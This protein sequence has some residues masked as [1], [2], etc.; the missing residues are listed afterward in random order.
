MIN[1]KKKLI[2][3]PLCSNKNFKVIIEPRLNNLNPQELYGAASGIKGSQRLVKCTQCSLIYENPRFDEKYIL[4]GYQM[5]NESDHDSQYS[6]RVK[7][8]LDTLIKN[9]NCLPKRGAKILD[10]GTAGGAFLEAAEKFG[11]NASGLEPNNYLVQKGKLK[12]LR[13]FKGTIKENNL[14]DLKFD[15]ITYWDVIEHLTNP[16]REIKNAKEYLKE[17][18]LILINY[19]DIGTIQAK[20][21]GEKYWWILSVHLV[22]FTKKTIKLLLEKNN[23]ELVSIKRYWQTLDFGYLILTAAK[24][25][26]PFAN[27]IYNFLPSYIKRLKI[28]YFASQFTVISRFK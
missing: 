21:A 24:L 26:F 19:P 5:S 27:L 28:P 17:N 9:E 16:M 15:L 20:L 6:N 1:P 13:I 11:Y 7:S 12:G 25:K 8:F 18:G 23:M 22:H 2:T 14:G 4:S 10:V 3:C